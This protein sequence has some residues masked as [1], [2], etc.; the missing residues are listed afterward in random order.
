MEIIDGSRGS[1]PAVYRRFVPDIRDQLGTSDDAS[2]E[3]EAR[4]SRRF[5]GKSRNLESANGRAS[6]GCET[7]TPW[8]YNASWSLQ[9]HAR[10]RKRAKESIR[11]HRC[12][13]QC[14]RADCGVRARVNTSRRSS[15]FH[16]H[17]E[18]VC[19]NAAMLLIASGGV[20]S[21]DQGCPGIRPDAL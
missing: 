11:S 7:R 9:K 8:V 16:L 3:V 6:Y 19:C 18:Q 4:G 12:L 2:G 15:D 1:F 17:R 14:N 20:E 21:T 5:L 10:A 13:S